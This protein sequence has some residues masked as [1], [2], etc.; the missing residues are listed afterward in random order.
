MPKKKWLI[1]I[2]AVLIILF[3]LGLFISK[4]HL[5][6]KYVKNILTNS[7]GKQLNADIEIGSFILDIKFIQISDIKI[8]EKNDS[9][10]F[11]AK[12][13]YIDYNPIKLLLKNL[14]F[15]GSIKK[16]SVFSPDI[17]IDL[18]KIT[19]PNKKKGD[20]KVNI[21]DKLKPN[22]YITNGK[23]QIK[24]KDEHNNFYQEIDKIDCISESI[25]NKITFLFSAKQSKTNGT[26]SIKGT[27][28]NKRNYNAIANLKNVEIPKAVFQKIEIEK[29]IVDGNIEINNNLFIGDS[30]VK[31]SK[32]LCKIN[33]QNLALNDV[34]LSCQNRDIIIEKGEIAF[35]DNLVNCSGKIKNVLSSPIQP[36]I[37]IISNNFILDNI[38]PEITGKIKF[39]VKIRGNVNKPKFVLFAHTPSLQ[40]KNIILKNIKLNSTFA[41]N[42]LIFDNSH[43]LLLNNKIKLNG[44]INLEPN[45]FKNSYLNLTFRANNFITTH[46]LGKLSGNMIA[47][48][49]GKWRDYQIKANL[50]SASFIND[51]FYTKFNCHLNYYQQNLSFS[52]SDNQPS[53]INHQPSTNYFLISGT[54]RNVLH[55]P[56][57]SVD[58]KTNSFPIANIYHKESKLLAYYNPVINTDINLHYEDYLECKGEIDFEN[59]SKS[60]IDGKLLLAMHYY[61]ENLVATKLSKKIQKTKHWPDTTK[62]K[63]SLKS[64]QLRLDGE[65]YSIDIFGQETQ[66]HWQV[67][68]GI[69]MKSVMHKEK[70]DNDIYLTMELPSYPSKIGSHKISG[71]NT[72]NKTFEGNFHGK[73]NIN[74]LLIGQIQRVLLLGGKPMDGF[75][76]AD[77]DFS[78]KDKLQIQG[79]LIATQMKYQKV[80][81]INSKVHFKFYNDEFMIDT[82]TVYNPTDDIIAGYGKVS[83]QD[84]SLHLHLWNNGIRMENIISSGDITGKIDYDCLVIGKIS[85]PTLLFN[86]SCED[87]KFG[88]ISFDNG[89]INIFQD[90]NFIYI[91]EAYLQKGKDKLTLKGEYAYNL[92]KKEFTNKNSDLIVFYQGDMLKEISNYI[93]YLETASSKTDIRLK[94]N[95][96]NK[97]INIAEGKI[98]IKNGKMKIKNQPQAITKIDGDITIQDG[99]VFIKNISGKMGDDKIYITNQ[100][101]Y[102]NRQI[103]TDF[104]NFGTILIRTGEKG[105]SVNYPGYLLKDGIINAKLTG[106]EDK[107][108]KIFGPIDSLTLY[109]NI[110]FKNGNGIY[111]PKKMKKKKGSPIRINLDLNLFFAKNI[112]YST[113][114]MNIKINPDSWLSLKGKTGEKI[115][116][117]GFFSSSFGSISLFGERFQVVK[118]EMKIDQ[119]SKRPKIIANFEKK[120]PDGTTIFL[121]IYSTTESVGQDIQKTEY[122][123]FKLVLRTDSPN[124]ETTAQI[125][126]KMRYGKDFEQLS[127]EE[128][129]SLYLDEAIKF[130]GQ[131]IDNKLFNP[132][133][134]PVETKLRRWL[135]LDFFK[136][137]TGLVENIILKSGILYS[138]ED[139][140]KSMEQENQDTEISRI[141]KEIVL[142]NLSLS[143][144]KYITHSWYVSYSALLQKGLEENNIERYGVIHQILFQYDLPL[145]FRMR[146][147]YIYSPE[148]ENVQEISL[149]KTFRF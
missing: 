21:L 27:Y 38:L 37:D 105:I 141:S 31:I 139:K 13:I 62:S 3:L 117:N 63:F 94:I 56:K 33:K 54:V 120:L 144:G 58:I 97:E 114:P 123:N 148:E 42:N 75:V 72:K 51:S 138:E 127:E 9:F 86:L 146:Y 149:Q 44:N 99:K 129:K 16:F 43:F 48:I 87:I 20:K 109:G 69:N 14:N 102:H 50:Y 17:K 130:A 52:L 91:R 8:S 132:L 1:F 118:V 92:F 101:E 22:I 65:G 142:N 145:G 34:K 119:Y 78:K 131:G 53:T 82:L 108:F 116:V 88:K 147:K 7:I 93:G 36:E 57:L 107:Y 12:Q 110:Y 76:N 66:N 73:L 125:F 32:L 96:P 40:Y 121:D 111:P 143:M 74:N 18:A 24:W 23:L 106:R 137:N 5:I 134:N 64:E 6:D 115:L 61:P 90:S 79:R 136:L 2:S 71:K 135:G 47:K 84:S 68:T 77:V 26:I 124:S 39:I 30:F 45:D 83:L 35:L 46:K 140:Y 103:K 29:G 85:E 98:R 15:V 100:F 104:L 89:K 81:N 41:E 25:K 60:K 128:K 70:R 113:Y 28:E 112:W 95:S 80:E 49:T 67:E 133:L 11:S 4:S 10:Y 122:G 126:S 59:N 19:L 55:N